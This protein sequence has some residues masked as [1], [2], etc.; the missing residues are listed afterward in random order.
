MQFITSIFK[1]KPPVIGFVVVIQFY[2]LIN[3]AFTQNCPP[4]IDFETGTFSGWTCYTGF[5]AAVNGQN[6]I[7]LTPSGGP[8][9]NR[10]TMINSYAANGLDEYGEFPVSCPN[11]SG[12]SIK[13]GNNSGGGQA[14]G[15]S[16][17][18]TIPAN[19]QSFNLIYNYAV[20]FEDPDHQEFEQPRM[21]I[22]IMNVTDNIRISCSSFAFFPNGS[23][24]PGFN[25]SL[26]S[27]GDTPVWYKDWSAVSINLDNHAGKTIRL[28]FKSADCTFRRHFGYAY[29]DVNTACSGKLTGSSF[30]PDDTVVNVVAPYGYQF[31]RWFNSSFTQVLGTNQL[32]SLSPLPVPGTTVAVV[33]FPYFGYGCKDTL[34]A[35][36]KD[37]LNFTLHAG[38]DTVS[39]NQAPVQIGGPPN[40]GIIY[41][42]EPVT[43]LSNPFS[44]NPYAIPAA[45][46]LYTITAMSTGGGCLQK[47]SVMVRA[48]EIDDSLYFSGKEIF[49]TGNGDSAVLRVILTD[50]IQWHKDDIAIPG[51][52]FPIYRV[53]EPGTYYAVLSNLGGCRVQTGRRTIN[54]S[55][56]PHVAFNVDTSRLCLA[57]NIFRFTNTSS[58]VFGT[59]QYK[60]IFGDGTEALTRNVDHH[61]T[62]PGIYNVKLIVTSNG[63]C[64]D[65]SQATIEIFPNPVPLFIAGSSC[66]NLPLAI[67]NNTIEN[68]SD[69]VN[70][71]WNFGN[72]STSVLRHPPPLLYQLPG[73]Y[74]I[75]LSVNS[76]LC[77]SPVSTARQQV[78]ID[79]P[80]A[81]I[82]Y[83]VKIAVENLPLQ[84]E[85]RQI[86][87]MVLWKPADGLGNNRSWLPV[88]RSM[89]D[90]KYL[91]EIKTNSG[92]ITVDTQIVVVIKNIGI[93]VP[94]A[95]TPDNNGVNDLL[96][97]VLYGIKA[98][99]YF[100]IY[101]RWG[102]LMYQSNNAEP[103][104][105][106][107]FKGNRQ[108]MN[109]Y[110]WLLEAIGADGKKYIK[111]GTTVLIR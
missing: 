45:T 69:P 49:C 89:E 23:S 35:E 51:A 75:S 34:Y 103:G 18:F 28:F 6:V 83:P 26:N 104:W 21:E 17:E 76:A 1:S 43:G 5:T 11:G 97:P 29:I 94:G 98:L 13:L 46:T 60:W 10:H 92:C 41:R 84:L 32:L 93:Y 80:K 96:K 86:G 33:L 19:Q 68:G 108:E 111:S 47:D 52:R 12:H 102:K 67:V 61:Y 105:D 65:S 106:G 24:L 39:C 30:C 37:D 36:L 16:Y 78:I 27:T 64:S 9:A 22:E 99:N 90:K 74:N 42:W 82:S 63:I 70:Y 15:I 79:K 87:E 95:F 8:V 77:P 56:I 57:G 40:P 2:L 59:M 20:V 3:T 100:R 14:E 25:L 50:S 48:S 66:I 31:Y 55:S 62:A 101:N 72:G 54:I 4:N 73:V 44:P 58:N 85:A 109:T 71:L 107:M 91:V 53:T 7:S 38:R 110:T 81:G 88:F